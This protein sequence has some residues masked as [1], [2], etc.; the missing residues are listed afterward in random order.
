MVVVDICVQ[1]PSGCVVGAPIVAS[2]V[3]VCTT[4]V[5]GCTAPALEWWSSRF[6]SLL[7]TR[8]IAIMVPLL[9]T[10]F[11]HFWY[12]LASLPV[13]AT[14]FP[15]P[16]SSLAA[17]LFELAR[18][19]RVFP[20]GS[21]RIRTAGVRRALESK[22]GKVQGPGRPRSRK[23]S[24]SRDPARAFSKN[25]VNARRGTFFSPPSSE[26]PRARSYASRHGSVECGDVRSIRIVKDSEYRDVPDFPSSDPGVLGY[27]G[28]Q[29][30][31][32]V[33]S[34]S[35]SLSLSLSLTRRAERRRQISCLPSRGETIS[36]FSLTRSLPD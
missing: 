6:R 35:Q 19:H 25:E 30:R 3:A 32:W 17:E 22:G 12:S 36:L 5:S 23:H 15:G 11:L 27:E 20:R 2:D 14:A 31:T 33:L 24:D 29:N 26:I 8:R 34:S 21:E 13:L 9:P 28:E 10:I 1:Q 16:G 7:R 18:V 4:V